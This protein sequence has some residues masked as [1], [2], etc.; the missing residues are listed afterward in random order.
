MG[1][2]VY[3][4]LRV[5]YISARSALELDGA[6][7]RFYTDIADV[8]RQISDEPRDDLH[9]L[10]GRIVFTILVTNT[11][12]H[13]KNHGFIYSGRGR[14]RLSPAFDI[15]PAPTRQ[16]ML[17]TGILEG[18]P[19]EASL[20]LALDTA[21]IFDIEREDAERMAAIVNGA[22]R[23][24]LREEGA[25]ATEIDAYTSAFQHDAME[26]ALALA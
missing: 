5:P 6:A 10:W 25:S 12:D 24:A 26:Q 2:T 14:W 20:A 9:E 7:G 13:L 16:R 8:I 21:G 18:E 23:E 17:Q 19:F 1:T 15:N 22:W 11:D 4:P 3:N